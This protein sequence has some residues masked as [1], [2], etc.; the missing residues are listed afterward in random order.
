MLELWGMQSALSLP[1]LPGSLWPR[2][3]ATDRVLSISQ[4]RTLTVVSGVLV[5]FAFS[6]FKLNCNV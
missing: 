4:N 5:F 3:V 1:S 6:V 2:V